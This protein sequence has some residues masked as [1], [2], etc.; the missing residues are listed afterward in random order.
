MNRRRGIILCMLAG[1][2]GPAV[3]AYAEDGAPAV[4]STGADRL[5]T[6]QTAKTPIVDALRLVAEQ[7][8]LNLVIGP[9][10]TGEVSVYLERVPVQTA[11]RAIAVNNGFNFT[12]DAGV[13]TVS[14]P[15]QQ[16]K[17]QRTPTARLV[18]RIFTLQCQDA[19]RVKEAL[20]Y[21]LTGDGKIKVLNENSQP[22]YGGTKLSELSGD[23]SN[24]GSTSYQSASNGS[25]STARIGAGN[26]VGL[27]GANGLGVT[28]EVAKN[29]RTLVVTDTEENL[30]RIADL[31]ADLDR[32]PAQV[33]IE[34]R[35]VEMSTDLQRQ[36]GID[37]DVNVLANGPIMNHELPT[38]WRAGFAPGSQIRYA[39]DGTPRTA[40]GMA[41]GT[42]DFSRFTALVRVHQS[43]N[44]I[45]LLANPRL[46]VFNN[47][48]AS[49]LVG[50]RYPL[51]R[52]N[53]T[54][55]GTLTE[56]FDTY[57]PV[58]IQLEVT[59]T[60]MADSRITMLVHPVTSAL[61]D[62]VIGTTG[63]RVRRILTREI[64]TRIVMLDGQTVVLGGLI[65]DRKTRTVNKT[66]GLGDL[67]GLDLLFRQESPGSQRVD[68]LVF[69][70]AH[71]EGAAQMSERDRSVF[72]M[73][74][75]QF[76]Q[77]ERLQDVQL[78]FEVPTEYKTPK[79]MFGDP[80]DVE[81]EGAEEGETGVESEEALSGQT[82]ATPGEVR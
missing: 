33:L 10:V 80:H 5:I 72:D 41:L 15:P 63:L 49:I 28:A 75:P 76:K 37:W 65:S 79:A 62:E 11:L 22:G 8:G 69:L 71:V 2:L 21:A 42:I 35:I 70:T 66:P 61:G 58:G 81:P 77:V 44:A 64:D 17:G 56:A 60:I 27:A 6:L 36:L 47:H 55:Q 51:L 40:N 68:L 39:P 73:Y 25:T 32:I 34:A 18:T 53:I 43:D 4:A 78:H 38:E 12:V 74:K 13:I 23:L 48:S 67:P 7:G 1:T 20:E 46:L 14:K 19:Q 24:T 26:G 31:I 45:R 57:I 16:E 9:E 30:A 54:D 29:A 3:C 82:S 52:A 59:P 50:E